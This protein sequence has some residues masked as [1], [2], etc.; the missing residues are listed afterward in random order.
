MLCS[1]ANGAPWAQHGIRQVSVHQQPFLN[2]NS[3]VQKPSGMPAGRAAPAGLRWLPSGLLK[4]TWCSRS[5]MATICLLVSS[6]GLVAGSHRISSAILSAGLGGV[7]RCGFR[8]GDRPL[9]QLKPGGIPAS[10]DF[11]HAWFPEK[12][13]PCKA[14]CPARLWAALGTPD[15]ESCQPWG[16]QPSTQ[17]AITPSPPHPPGLG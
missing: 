2:V 9:Q 12:R 15:F 17:D 7:E 1:L 11:K 14:G 16:Q 8:E 5:C 13:E 4:R 6:A 3:S 10:P